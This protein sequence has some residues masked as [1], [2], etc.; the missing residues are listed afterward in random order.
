M[1]HIP[2]PDSHALFA[3][4]QQTLGLNQGELARLLGVSRRTIQRVYA[5]GIIPYS[6]YMHTL[7]R[8]VHRRDAA[9]AA[10]LAAEGGQTLVTLGIVKP[11]PPP[12]PA[13]P[14][15]PSAPMAPPRKAPPVGLMVE[16]IVCA[17]ADTMQTPPAAVRDVLR[18]A[19]ARAR[20]LG[21]TVEEIDD[22]LTPTPSPIEQDLATEAPKKKSAEGKGA[23][24]GK[25]GLRS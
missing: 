10:E 15:A 17:A 8:A 6:E 18:A 20:G 9:L 16:S 4:A 1:P 3:R 5:A 19:F 11:A 25:R 23:G 21:L 13:P 2:G 22:V 14:A 24:Q 7:A 12:L